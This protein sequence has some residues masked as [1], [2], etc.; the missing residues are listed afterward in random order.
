MRA[1]PALATTV[2]T[3][4]SASVTLAQAQAPADQLVADARAL[5]TRAYPRATH[6]DPGTP[7]TWGAA[8]VPYL[9]AMRAIDAEYQALFEKS[10]GA[11][12]AVGESGVA[13][14]EVCRS[15]LVRARDAV[16]GVLAS[17]HAVAAGPP[18]GMRALSDPQNPLAQDGW[19][20]LL[21]A[22]AL[23]QLESQEQ[24]RAG[25]I[26]GAVRTCVDSFALGRDASYGGGLMAA[27]A[28][29]AILESSRLGCGRDLASAPPATRRVLAE[30]LSRVRATIAPFSQVLREDATIG[31]LRVF[32]RVLDD[33]HR[34]S[35][36]PVALALASE[37]STE[38]PTAPQREM[39]VD[40]WPRYIHFM[41]E[42][43]AAADLPAAERRSRFA[44]A[45][46]RL[47]S[48]PNP[49]AKTIAPDWEHY[50]SQRDERMASFDAL[51]RDLRSGGVDKPR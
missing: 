18:E 24:K 22:S 37:M 35:L 27:M 33:E 17:T 16:R 11:C 4:L 29:L 10:T 14:P 48:A 28:G 20:L 49:L 1:T 3:L 39:I 42:I 9:T 34:R 47:R 5:S 46:E 50:A 44:A 8:L 43:V 25:D 7:G 6:V 2:A 15:L 19:F 26:A 12:H 31:M 32:V 36:P 45:T 38:P 30:Q 23:A 13:L 40:V 21:H 51:I 41:D